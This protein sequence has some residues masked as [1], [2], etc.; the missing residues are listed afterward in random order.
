HP[1]DLKDRMRKRIYELK[2][3]KDLLT[4]TTLPDTNNDIDTHG[5]DQDIIT[6]KAVVA[7]TSTCSSNTSTMSTTGNNLLNLQILQVRDF[8]STTL[9]V[10]LIN[11]MNKHFIN[12]CQVVNASFTT[13][14][15]KIC[16][17]I[18]SQ[19]D[20]AGVETSR[21]CDSL[22]KLVS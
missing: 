22:K 20:S 5:G 17:T 2:R 4:T 3:K 19:V 12:Y 21:I 15:E 8:D 9:E 6:T 11:G 18:H 14:D 7:S 1:I 16:Y 13:F 10:V